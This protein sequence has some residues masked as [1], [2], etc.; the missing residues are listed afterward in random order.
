MLGANFYSP[1]DRARKPFR[2][3][4]KI[5]SMDLTDS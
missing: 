2:I 3:E 5:M 4:V 1:L